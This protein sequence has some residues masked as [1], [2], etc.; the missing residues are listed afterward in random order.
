[1][2]NRPSHYVELGSKTVNL[3]KCSNVKEHFHD[4]HPNAIITI[5]RSIKALSGVYM[6]WQTSF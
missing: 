1:M 2:N 4:I 3:V 5:E 6:E